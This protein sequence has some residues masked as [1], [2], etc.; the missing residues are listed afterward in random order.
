MTSDILMTNITFEYIETK[1]SDVLRHMHVQACA[2]NGCS[3]YAN[4]GWVDGRHYWIAEVAAKKAKGC[5]CMIISSVAFS[6]LLYF[7]FE[8]LCNGALKILSNLEWHTFTMLW[9]THSNLYI[10]S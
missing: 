6:H 3:P 2:D 1:Y 5:S 10:W 4:C 8:M 7:L 9:R